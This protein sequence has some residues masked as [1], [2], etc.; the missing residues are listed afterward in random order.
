MSAICGIFYR[1]GRPVSFAPVSAMVS[2]LAH[3][4]SDGQGVWE[5]GAVGLGHVA[6][7]SVPE[8]VGERA[9]W[10]DPESGVVVTAD[11]RI[12]NRD[13]LLRE[14]GLGHAGRVL[15]DVELIARAY[16]KWEQACVERLV[17]DFAFALW[18]PRTRRLFCARDPMGVRPFFYFQDKGRFLFATQIRAIFTDSSVSRVLN[19]LQIGAA[20]CG[21]PSFDDSTPFKAVRMLEPASALSVDASGLHIWKYWRLEMAREIRLARDD[22]YTD[23]LEEILQRAIN[24]RLR[25]TGRVGCLLSG[26]LDASTCLALALKRGNIAHD[27]LSAFSWALPEGNDSGGSDERPFIEA[28][29][30]EYPL[31][32]T[33]ISSDSSIL[34]D[35]PPEMRAHRDGPESRIDH[36]QM[37]PTFVAARAKGVR[38][39]LHGVAGDD[40]VSHA[41]PDYVV[42][43][44][45][46]GDWA[47]L[48][49]EVAA[50][51]PTGLREHWRAWQRLLRPLVRRRRWPKYFEYQWFYRHWCARVTDLS[52]RQIPL[53]TRLV[54]ETGLLSYVERVARPHIASAWRN[55]V[56]A[57]QIYLLTHTH[58]TADQ[59][60]VWDYAASYGLECRC[61][62]L[63]RRVIEFGVGVPPSQ[64][65]SGGVNRRLLRRVASR[66]LPAEIAQRTDKGVTMPDMDRVILRSENSLQSR[67]AVWRTRPEVS[68]IVDLDHL[69]RDMNEV[70]LAIRTRAEK[71]TPSLPLCRGAMLAEYLFGG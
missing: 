68:R 4:G 32:H 55:P 43:R 27:R 14:L 9:P 30:R 58:V 25:S 37:V 41:A 47:A 18:D 42:S 57:L 63:D 62:Y 67:M 40:T 52:L 24:A 36:C 28:F 26:G 49:A 53:S 12:D 15:G 17:G 54:A 19:D 69:E 2:A 1:D 29:R 39:I 31:D 33:Y 13:D 6:Q 59:L 65:R 3:W 70:L 23:A 61:P 11:A 50:G 46:A 60:A 45:L 48:R 20:L 5:E 35:F 51:K 38:V 8:A 64:H 22:D 16:L 66:H 7:W 34:L 21:L 10:R 44:L 71:W 56:R